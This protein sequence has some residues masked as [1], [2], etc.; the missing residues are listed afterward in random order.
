VEARANPDDVGPKKRELLETSGFRWFDQG[1]M[2]ITFER[3]KV[4]RFRFVLESD[5]E[6]LRRQIADNSYQ[7]EWRNYGSPLGAA[8]WQC[9]RVIAET[10]DVTREKAR[11]RRR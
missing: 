8:E 4:F 7:G 1:D 5:I 9:V 2:W 6:T 10:Q 3:R 11:A